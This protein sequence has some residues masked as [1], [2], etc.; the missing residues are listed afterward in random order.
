MAPYNYRVNR[1]FIRGFFS[2]G[3][4]PG[5]VTEVKLFI[6]ADIEGVSGYVDSRDD[7][8]DRHA[9]RLAMTEDVN[10]AIAGAMAADPDVAITVTDAHGSKR[11]LLPDRLD[12]RA[13]LVRGGPR[14]LGMVAGIDERH[15]MAFFLG[16]HGKPGSGGVLEHVFSG[17]L[18]HVAL[19]GE[20]VGEY[21]LNSYALGAFDVPVALVT[22]DDILEET[23]AEKQPNTAYVR[24]KRALGYRAAACRPP[25]AVR[26]ELRESATAA[27]NGTSSPSP[28]GVKPPISVRVSFRSALYADHIGA[29]PG[30][31]RTADSRTVEY[32]AENALEAYRFVRQAK[33]IS[34]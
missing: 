10:A 7:E 20:P 16:Y 30:V 29:W 8:E 19:D 27:L 21:E 28:F 24:T 11:N 2:P 34:P 4:T 25:E 14:E 13:T 6:S 9:V 33:G 18:T 5:A 31:E 32:T 1:L 12:E 15:D 23:V 3:T 22:G 26:S 17:S